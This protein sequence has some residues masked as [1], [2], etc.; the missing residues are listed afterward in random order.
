MKNKLQ[1]I[2]LSYHK[3]QKRVFDRIEWNCLF[4]ILKRFGLGL[5]FTELIAEVVTNS[6]LSKPINLYRSTRQGCPLSPTLFLFA[7]EPL[8]MAIHKS[9]EITGISIGGLEHCIS[10]FADDVVLYL[11]NLDSSVQTVDQILKLFGEFSG[12]IV[13][14]TKVLCHC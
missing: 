12:Y 3:M 7:I 10:L 8:D 4:E 5:L 14:Q 13:K 11:S 6:Q 9:S 2:K 1:W